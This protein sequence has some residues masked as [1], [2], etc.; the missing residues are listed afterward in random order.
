MLHTVYTEFPVGTSVGEANK[1]YEAAWSKQDKVTRNL[2]LGFMVNCLG[3]KKT[4]KKSRNTS[5]CKFSTY[6]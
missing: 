4:C 6:T 2:E 1:S 3:N 5:M